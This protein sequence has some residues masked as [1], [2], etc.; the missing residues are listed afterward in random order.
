MFIK[1]CA[2]IASI[3]R[4]AYLIFGPLMALNMHWETVTGA[5]HWA[6]HMPPLV[7]LCAAGGYYLAAKGE[8]LL[9]G[10]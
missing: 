6:D 8:T 10:E 7:L 2:T 5:Y 4:L 3:T 1:A 9:R